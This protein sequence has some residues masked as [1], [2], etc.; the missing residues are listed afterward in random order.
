MRTTLKRGIGRGAEV[1]GNGNGVIPPGALSPVTIYR[2]PPPAR[3]SLAKVIGKFFLWLFVVLLML[4]S[5][6]VGGFYL[7]AHESAAALGCRSLDCKRTQQRLDEIKDAH[8]PAIALVIGY[9]H[10]A[11]DGTGS[12]S[13]SDTMMLLRADPSTQ[14]ISL[15]SL[16]RDLVVPIYCPSRSGG[17]A[18]PV[19]HERINNAYAFCGATGSLETVRHLTGVPINY[20]ISVNFSGFVATVN[21]LG[22]VWLDVDRRYYNK[23]VGTI[24][25]NYANIDLQPGYQLM[26]GRQAL[27]FVRFRHTDSDLYRLARQQ[28]FVSAMRQQA[29]H[30]LGAT[31]IVRIIN[32]IAHHHYV[33]IAR[34]GGGVDLNTIYSYAKFAYGLPAGH[35]FQTKL[36]QVTGYN[37]LFASQS[38]IDSAVQDFLNPDVE[39]ARTSTAVALGRKLKK[40]FV[41]AP[42][43]TTLTVLNGNGRAGSASNASY[44]LAQKGYKIVLPPSGQPANAPTWTY[45]HSKA[46]FDPSRSA[47]KG[48]AGGIAR[49]VGSTDVEPLPGPKIKQGSNGACVTLVVGSTFHDHLAPVTLP[50]APVRQPA[51]VRSDGGTTRAAL[52]KYKKRL[53][54]RLEYPSV[55]YSGSQLDT[56]YGETPVRVYKLGGQPTIRLTYRFGANQYWGIQESAWKDAPI[57][58]DK[59]L[60]QFVN[61]RR[62][63]L[64]YNSGHLHMVVLRTGGATYWVVNSLLDELNNETM[65]AIARGFRPMTR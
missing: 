34:G 62:F 60:T 40:R 13:R 45:F 46:Y 15:L 31:S 36:T 59:S 57:L 28:E 49:L 37:E 33:E 63:D 29:A 61:G 16:P 54:F 51:H 8:Q 64:Y 26:N 14:T 7:W 65:L 47:C 2:A 56:G 20:L 6:L 30:S 24:E 52:V 35:V 1:N 27:E 19:D 32:T 3:P 43:K 48:A 50:Q 17:A 18:V 12:P 53:P 39:T 38:A 5:G 44:L 4:V 10:R 9:D 11:G 42:S 21:K 55:L 22:G 23:N 41:L 58:A 25:T